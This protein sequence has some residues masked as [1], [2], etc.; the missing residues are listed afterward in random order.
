MEARLNTTSRKNQSGHNCSMTRYQACKNFV[1]TVM[2]NVDKNETQG[3]TNLE[4]TT[5]HG[6]D[7]VILAIGHFRSKSGF[8]PKKTYF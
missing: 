2:N 1:L 8:N 4:Q 7:E 5:K 6:Q 3:N